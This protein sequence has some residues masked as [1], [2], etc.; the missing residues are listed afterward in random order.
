MKDNF[1]HDNLFDLLKVTV[2]ERDVVY[3]GKIVNI[4]SL[5]LYVSMQS[6]YGD[7]GLTGEFVMAVGDIDTARKLQPVL[8]DVLNSNFK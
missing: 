8:E 7:C 2:E 4:N 1:D 6:E 3:K 5:V